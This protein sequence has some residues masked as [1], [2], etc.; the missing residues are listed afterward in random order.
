MKD[1]LIGIVA[2]VIGAIVGYTMNDKGSQMASLEE[3]NAGLKSQLAEKSGAPASTGGQTIANVKKKGFVQ[4]GVSQGVPGF[5]NPDAS[6][7]WTGIDVDV[8]R[9]VAA[10]VLGLTPP[11]RPRHPLRWPRHRHCDLS[12]TFVCGL[13]SPAHRARARSRHLRRE[14]PCSFAAASFHPPGVMQPH[15]G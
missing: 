11:C 4:C 15:C 14:W 7:N 3:E 2:L 13:S 9:A 8:C 12:S 1:L 10:A 6:D 5:S